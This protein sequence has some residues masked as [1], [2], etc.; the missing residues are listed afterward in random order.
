MKETMI[1]SVFLALF[2]P[3]ISCSSQD[4]VRSPS[5][6]VTAVEKDWVSVRGRWKIIA[7]TAQ[8]TAL[9]SINSVHIVCD[10]PSRTCRE[11]LA[12]LYPPEGYGTKKNRF[13]SALEIS[14]EVIEWSNEIIR[15]NYRAPVADVELSISV[16]DTFV[17]RRS[18]ETT[19]R[20]STTSDPNVHT[21]YVL[22]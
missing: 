22:E 17:E 1:L 12:L 11:T 9:P 3:L 8:T 14:Y 6:N 21:H 2:L 15:A 4:E 13:L 10:K 16:K 20:G 18:R 7:N 19:A 5:K